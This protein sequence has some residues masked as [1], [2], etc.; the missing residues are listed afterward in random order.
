MSDLKDDALIIERSIKSWEFDAPPKRGLH[1]QQFS[2]P[3]GIYGDL[4]TSSRP[5]PGV[6]AADLELHGVSLTALRLQEYLLTLELK[7]P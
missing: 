1:F 6:N 2:L 7:R 3:G 4:H 5:L